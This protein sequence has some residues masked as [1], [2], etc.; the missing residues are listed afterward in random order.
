MHPARYCET[1]AAF[2]H[3]ESECRR[4]PPV[5][6][7]ASVNVVTTRWPTVHERNWCAMHTFSNLPVKEVQHADDTV[8]G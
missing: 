4:F 8:Y 1:C 2:A 6:L 5:V 7:A 3:A